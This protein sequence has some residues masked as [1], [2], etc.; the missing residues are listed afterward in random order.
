MPK[1]YHLRSSIKELLIQKSIFIFSHVDCNTYR[2]KSGE[3]AH[4]RRTWKWTSIGVVV[5]FSVAILAL[6][7][8]RKFHHTKLATKCI[9]SICEQLHFKSVSCHW[10]RHEKTKQICLKWKLRSWR[11]ILSNNPQNRSYPRGVNAR[12]KLFDFTFLILFV[13]TGSDGG[14]NA[15]LHPCAKLNWQKRNKTKR[16]KRNAEYRSTLH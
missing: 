15:H 6:A 7:K 5:N 1:G 16:T 10:H 3:I 8:L 2:A 4:T 13:D 12:S 11:S 14:G 9:S